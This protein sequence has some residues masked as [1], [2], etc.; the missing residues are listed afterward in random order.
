[1]LTELPYR[2]P[3]KIYRSPM[4]FSRYDQSGVWDAYQ[5]QEIELIVLLTE[6]QEYLVHAGRDLP[7]FYRSHGIQTVH[8]PVPDFGIPQDRQAWDQGLAEVKQAAQEGKNVAVHCLAGR[9]RTGIFLACLA[10]TAL[11]LEGREAIKWVRRS[12]PG[13]MENSFQEQFVVNY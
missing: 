6:P 7:A 3:G 1:M 9:G 11:D 12:L 13:A 4:P 5:K 10:K 2:Y 8:I